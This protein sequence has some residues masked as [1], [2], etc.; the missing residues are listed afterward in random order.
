ME[1]S[2]ETIEW[3]L[4]RSAEIENDSGNNQLICNRILD[5]LGRYPHLAT[6][7]A[8][9]DTALVA[10]LLEHLDSDLVDYLATTPYQ[11]AIQKFFGMIENNELSTV[12][13][14]IN[15]GVVLEKKKKSFRMGKEKGY[16]GLQL[17]LEND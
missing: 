16:M 5:F 3:R 13:D 8:Y 14:C 9:L 12:V 7:L 15:S 4:I 10:K 11:P 2:V 6:H 1:Q 17:E